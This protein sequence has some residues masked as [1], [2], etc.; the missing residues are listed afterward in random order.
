MGTHHRLT[1]PETVI[2]RSR[3]CQ[4]RLTASGVSRRHCCIRVRE[5]RYLVSDL[6]SRNG[7]R[8]N[9]KR[10]HEAD[11]ELGIGDT[12]S[13]GRASIHMVELES[14][15]DLIEPELSVVSASTHFVQ[16]LYTISMDTLSKHADEG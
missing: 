16:T 1:S 6:G 14:E 3:G 8:I 2:G 5:E 15:A 7:T 11:R 13:I 12:L 4:I 10:V 9:G